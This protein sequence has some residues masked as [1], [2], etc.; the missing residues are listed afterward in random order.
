M[1]INGGWSLIYVVHQPVCTRGLLYRIRVNTIEFIDPCTTSLRPVTRGIIYH[2]NIGKLPSVSSSSWNDLSAIRFLLGW[3]GLRGKGCKHLQ[4]TGLGIN[5]NKQFPGGTGDD[6][7][8][9]QR[10]QQLSSFIRRSVNL[11]DRR[12]LT[13]DIRHLTRDTWQRQSTR[14]IRD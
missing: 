4:G 5:W 8:H 13:F 2:K 12:H 14:Y 7:I 11:I 9:D 6:Y 3:P 10:T 1:Q